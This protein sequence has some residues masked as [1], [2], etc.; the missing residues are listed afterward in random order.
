VATCEQGGHHVQFFC[1][2]SGN[3]GYPPLGR[4]L[5]G[6]LWLRRQLKN[7]SLLTFT[8]ECQGHDLAVRKFQRIVMG[9][10]LFLLICRKI[11]IL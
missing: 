11:A 8:Q 3:V 6:S 4:R 2:R 9:R 5:T 1:E 10:H 7:R